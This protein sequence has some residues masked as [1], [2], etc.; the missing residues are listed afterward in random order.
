[1]RPAYDVA[2]LRAAEASARAGRPEGTLMQRA[3]A[4][5]ARR[6]AAMLGRVYGAR[7]LLLVGAGDN[8]GDALFAGARLA[9]RGARVSALLAGPAAHQAGRA[10]L[11]LAGGRVS[12]TAEAAGVLDRPADL[13]IDGLTGLGGRG[14]L[15]PPAAGWLPRLAG[16]P[17]LA[18]DLPSGVDADT[19]RVDGPA[20]RADVTVTF[21]GLK[22]GLLVDPGAGHA[23]LVECVD[24]GMAPQGRPALRVPDAADVA[25]WLPGAAAESDKY[26]RG[27]LGVLAGS[28]DYAGPQAAVDLVRARWPEAVCTVLGEADTDPLAA[29]RVQAWVAGPGLGTGGAARARL[30]RL[31]EAEVPLLADADALNLLA[32]DPGRLAGRAAPTLITPHAGEFARLTGGERGGV[33]ADR[34]TRARAAA[35]RLRVTVLLKGS[36]TLVCADG[37]AWVNPT[38]TPLLATAGSGDVLSGAAGALLARGL[39]PVRAAVAAAYLHGLS[40]RLAAAGEG[41]RNREA[42]RALDVVSHWP[43]AVAA[44][45]G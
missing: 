6:A 22:P 38:G 26:R 39:D 28:A 4:A 43:A 32:E 44:V 2:A 17:V 24:I 34:L 40:A 7:V 45:L 30:G 12:E 13:V 27:V 10:A 19:G 23:G 20:V 16:R 42:I 9:G 31:L 21:G 5:T 3:A 25:G 15:R 33:E 8:G 1:M 36:T 35:D 37:E 11:L 18:V 29:G 14:G 41:H